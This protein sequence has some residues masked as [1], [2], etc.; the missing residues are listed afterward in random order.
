VSEAAELI[1]FFLR[2]GLVGEACLRFAELDG[3]LLFKSRIGDSWIC[4]V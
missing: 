4:L 3:L 1:D 2:G